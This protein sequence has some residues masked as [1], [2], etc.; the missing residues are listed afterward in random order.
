MEFIK[1]NDLIAQIEHDIEVGKI[2]RPT[3]ALML[4]YI[5]NIPRIVVFTEREYMEKVVCDNAT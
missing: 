3:A 1:K 5:S 2:A 4:R